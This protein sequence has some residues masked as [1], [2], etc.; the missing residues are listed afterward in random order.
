MRIYFSNPIVG[1]E[2]SVLGI[3]KSIRKEIEFI[4]FLKKK[5]YIN[6]KSQNNLWY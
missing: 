5:I 4:N 3:F 2:N 6:V 1:I